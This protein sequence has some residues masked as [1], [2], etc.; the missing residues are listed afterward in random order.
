MQLIHKSLMC[1]LTHVSNL[2]HTHVDKQNKSF[3]LLGCDKYKISPVTASNIS[4]VQ[5]DIYFTVKLYTSSNYVFKFSRN[6]IC[7]TI[8]Q[9]H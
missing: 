4:R 1:D 8:G 7:H 6:V 3:L 5:N 2:P 9:F